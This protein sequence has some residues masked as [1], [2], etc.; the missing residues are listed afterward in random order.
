MLRILHTS[1]WH[2]GHILHD[3]PRD[4]EHA[5]FLDWLLDQL[6]VHEVDALL[7]A[8][9][10]FDTAN[11][12]SRA[13][14]TWFSFLKQA[15]SR[16]PELDIV[17]IGGNH[18]SAARLE[19]ANPVLEALHIHVVGVLPR[20]AD[21]D[22]DEQ[23]LLVPLH[24]A[25]GARAAWCVAVPF[26]RSAD[27]PRDVT[28]GESDGGDPLIAGVRAVYGRALGLARARR[29]DGEALVAMGHAYMVGGALSEL[30]ERWV[31]GGNQ[32]ALPVDIFTEDTDYVALGHLHRAQSVGDRD[33]V[34]YAGSP[35]PLALD[36]DTY[37]HQVILADVAA[38]RPVATQT[39]R[40]PRT[41]DILRI[42]GREGGPWD[43]VAKALSALPV[44]GGLLPPERW[45][46]LEVRVQVDGPRP[47]LRREVEALLANKATRL[48]KL[49]SMRAGDGAALAHG[50]DGR[51]LAELGAHEVLSRKWQRDY[52]CA[53]PDPV[54]ACFHDLVDAVG[55]GTAGGVA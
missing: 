8:G 2:L 40:V 12:P 16:C 24:D 50:E 34:R 20:T 27:L 54:L 14:R 26:L 11:P 55:Q 4:R 22:L 23:R 32:H 46:Y 31:L 25:S 51:E 5:A 6:E 13:M 36:E 15:R 53:P 21:G 38:G 28:P 35:I 9:D 52:G 17:V 39:L 42:P 7:I 3:L 33:S 10:I 44:R 18:D 30:S 29:A 37:P 41:I 47:G 19:A 43:E 48:V 1:D 49:V 45:P